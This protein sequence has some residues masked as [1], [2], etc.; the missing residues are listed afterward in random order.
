MTQKEALEILKRGHNVFLTGPAGS[1]KTHVLSLFVRAQRAAGIKVAVTASTGIAAAHL[2]GLTIHAWS[3]AGIKRDLDRAS[4]ERTAKRPRL[5]ERM[6]KTA[7]L[8]IDEISMLDQARLDLVDQLCRHLRR[9]ERPF[10]GLQVVL[11]GDFF[12]L[13]PVPDA[14]I[15]S[16]LAYESAAWENLGL[17]VCYLSEQ[18][19]QND[20]E[21][22]NL[23]GEIRSGQ[24][25]ARSRE[26]LRN[27]TTGS[28]APGTMTELYTHNRDVDAVNEREL[29]KLNAFQKSYAMRE[30]GR[31]VH[32][33]TLKKGCLAPANLVLKTGALVMFVKNNFDAGYVNGTLG[34]ISGFDTESGYPIVTTIRGQKIT[35]ELATWVFEEDGQ[36]KAEVR[37]IPLRL[38]WAITVHKSQ[39]MSLDA[40]RIDLSRAFEK[41]MGYVA[42]SRVRSLNGIHLVGLNERALEVSAEVARF[43]DELRRRSENAARELRAAQNR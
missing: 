25:S 33:E 21:F 40:A 9:D 4:L 26:L 39:G 18:H 13:P 34:V 7:I 41:G 14:G 37:Q 11:S 32:L 30:T 10:G 19:R 42:L 12:Q 36:I 6:R 1:G 28:A 16:R 3:G 23:L 17:R 27:R 38:A 2:G 24:V 15:V 43:D 29:E 35:A 20:P 5:R 31:K 8:V 22:L